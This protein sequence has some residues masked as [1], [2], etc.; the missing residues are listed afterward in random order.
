MFSGG[1]RDYQQC[2]FC[3]AEKEV[4]IAVWGKNITDKDIDEDYNVVSEDNM[5]NGPFALGYY[6]CKTLGEEQSKVVV[7]GSPVFLHETLDGAT[8]FANTEIFVNALN[9]MCDMKLN[10][11]VP[12]KSFQ[13]NPILVSQGL[14]LLYA[15]LLIVLLPLLEIVAGIVIMIVRRKK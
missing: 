2:I 1:P 6:S 11:S 7:I 3:K 9:Y 4:W 15:G 10:T 5:E 8:S 14:V 13:M 12:A